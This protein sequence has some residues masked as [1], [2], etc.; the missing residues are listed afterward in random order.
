MKQTSV[1]NLQLDYLEN[2]LMIEKSESEKNLD[3]AYDRVI[4]G[5]DEYDKAGDRVERQL[6]VM[7][8]SGC[9]ALIA[10]IIINYVL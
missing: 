9:G 4:K 8:S 5:F 1:S 6:L 7:L 10:F 3:E 2:W